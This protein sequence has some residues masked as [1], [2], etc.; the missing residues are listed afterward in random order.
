MENSIYDVITLGVMQI[1]VGLLSMD[2]N[3]NITD[4]IT[5]GFIR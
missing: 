1:T 5:N 3:A 4:Y 2:I